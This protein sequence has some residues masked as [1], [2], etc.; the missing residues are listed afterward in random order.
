[1]MADQQQPR[2]VHLNG[3]IPLANADEVFRVTGSILGGRL[4]RIPDGET[5]VRAN[6]IGWQREVFARNPSFETIPPDPNAYAP[7]PRFKMRRGA[8]DVAFDSLG[9][10]DAAL[11]SYAVFADLKQSGMIPDKYRFQVSLPTP[12]APVTAFIADEERAVVQQAYERAMFAELDR[13]AS[14]IPHSE[15]AI[16]WDVAVEFGLLEGVAFTN[17]A[18]VKAEIIEQLVQLGNQ[19]PGDVELG[20]HLCYG[21]AGHKHFVE[22]E[23]T[24]KLV[25]VA[26]GISA[27][28]QRSLNWISMPVP[29]NRSDDAYFAPLKNLQLHPETEL[30]LGLV[31]YTD[32]V[33]GTRRRIE[34]AQRVVA[35][36][37]V[38]TECGFGRRPS[39]TIPDLL[40]IHSEVAAPC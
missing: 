19:V 25:D 12:L 23:D 16:Q 13:I 3:S 20:Y 17:Y 21:D 29:R 7:L 39:E 34:A 6:W 9:Y 38:A 27:G 36:F 35:Q 37:G 18:H 30:Y 26:N 28:L 40:R 1:M 11:A 31:H 33:E 14:G 22:P 4:H 15:L 5:G 24:T 2:G 8:S 10:A 32:G